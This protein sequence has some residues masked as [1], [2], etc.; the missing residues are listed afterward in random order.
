MDR[1]GKMAFI[2]QLLSEYAGGFYI[3]EFPKRAYK[4]AEVIANDHYDFNE[5]GWQIHEIRNNIGDHGVVFIN[6]EKRKIFPMVYNEDNHKWDICYYDK[7]EQTK[8][9]NSIENAINSFECPWLW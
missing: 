3:R 4:L 1:T 5:E 9:T 8:K 2:K 6:I 7:N